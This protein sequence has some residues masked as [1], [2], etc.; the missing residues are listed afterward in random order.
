MASDS[1]ICIINDLKEGVLSC[2]RERV[3]RDHTLDMEIR[4]EDIRIYYRG[5][6]I[7]GI[8]KSNKRF[9]VDFDVKYF[10]Y[11]NKDEKPD[12][13]NAIVTDSEGAKEWVRMIPVLKQSMD[14]YFSKHKKE[15]RDFQQLVVRENNYGRIANSTDYFICDMEYDQGRKRFDLVAAHWPSTS[16][17]RKNNKNIGLAIIEIKYGQGSMDGSAGILKHIDDFRKFADNSKAVSKFKEEMEMSFKRKFELGLI[18]GCEKHIESFN[19][20][21]NFILMLANHDPA[22]ESFRVA[23]LDIKD[24]IKKGHYE[25][26]WLRRIK[27]ATANYFGCG[28]Y[29][30]AIYALDD[31][32]K[33]Y[34]NRI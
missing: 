9:A 26:D 6:R 22:S 1:D 2:F 32:E 10:K 28:L 8:M 24:R 30:N 4:R 25:S 21:P 3:I 13:P 7:I 14:F 19:D 31:F 27:I 16:S 5:G 23:M 17:E 18:T 33:L 20:T 29:D 15:E 11:A 34:L 12:L